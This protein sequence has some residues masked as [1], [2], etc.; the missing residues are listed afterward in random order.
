MRGERGEPGGELE[1]QFEFLPPLQV[2]EILDNRIDPL[3]DGAHVGRFR[4]TGP[5]GS[6]AAHTSSNSR[7]G[8]DRPAAARSPGHDE[9]TPASHRAWF[10]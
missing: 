6:I 8:H 10:P 3:G 7:R 4:R 2:A 5:A 9:V 1:E